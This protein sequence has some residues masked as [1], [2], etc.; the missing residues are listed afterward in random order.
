MLNCDEEK[1][2]LEKEDL[3]KQHAKVAEEAIAGWEKAENEV[4]ILKQQL[5]AAVQQ[6]LGLEVR[7]NHLDGALK[8]CV[9]QLRQAKEEQEQR[10]HDA[11]TEKSNE[12]E[13]ARYKLESELLEL[14]NQVQEVEDK[15]PVCIDTGV[16]LKLE[17]LEKENAAL[18]LKLVYLSEEL[19]I[20]TIERDLSTQAAEMASKQH[21]ESI[22]KVA[23]LE[24][25][26]R[27]LQAVV[28]KSLLVNEHKSPAMSSLSVESLADSHS[29]NGERIKVLDVDEYKISGIDANVGDKSCSALT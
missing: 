15:D 12:W 7:V 13:T 26:C 20:R 3:V 9:R 23:K 11:L 17:S 27:R 25:E 10:I 1:L 8:E 22:K 14:Q 28:R 6:N 18:K 5:E 29:D 21:L 4:S 16:Q 24:A 19:E 2:K